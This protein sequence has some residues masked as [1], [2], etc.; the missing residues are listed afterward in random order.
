MLHLNIPASHD[1][2]WTL[3][4]RK[5][6]WLLMGALA[7]EALL[8]SPGG[9]WASAKQSRADMKALG[10]K[11]WTMVRGFYADSGGF[12]LRPHHTP[13]FPLSAKQI[14]F[15]VERNYIKVPDLS[16]QEISDK[17][18]ADRFTKTLACL[19][20]GWFM[21]QCAARRIQDLSISLELSTA[22]IMICT[23]AIYFF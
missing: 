7:P 17:S 9:Q 6:R 8:L 18:K 4:F 20:T 12:V 16:E 23:S 19:Q 5:L 22:A 13:S 14:R 1:G 2:S 21:T 11:H 15:L 10:R 3:F